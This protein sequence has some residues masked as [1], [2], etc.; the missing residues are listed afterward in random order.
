M[1]ERNRPQLIRIQPQ[2]EENLHILKEMMTVKSNY[3]FST[4]AHLSVTARK[5]THTNNV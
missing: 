5:K 4:T 2:L 3:F 1:A